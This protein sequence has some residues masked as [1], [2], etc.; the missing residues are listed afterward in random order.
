MAFAVQ[1]PRV[2]ERPRSRLLR[3]ALYWHLLSLDAPTVAVLWA[4]SFERAARVHIS[5]SALA[6]LGVGTWLIYVA[7]RL[8]DARPSRSSVASRTDLHERHFFH[9]R[10]RRTL[11]AVA[12]PVAAALLWLI[13]RM[14]AIDRRNDAILFAVA[15]LYF[16]SVHLA[17]P[18]TRRWFAR[19][20]MV[21]VVFA[22]ATAV[23][24]WSQ[25]HQSRTQMALL[26]LLFAA[27]CCLNTIA[28][29]VWEQSGGGRRFSVSR[30]AGVLAACAVAILLG[31]GAHGSADSA[32]VLCAGISAMVLLFLDHLH[33]RRS[34]DDA[35]PDEATRWLLLLRVAADAALLT[36][37]LFV[38]LW[39]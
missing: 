35:A 16:G 23:P 6:V 17:V 14:P 25:A 9:A 34:A 3:G 27:L 32:L 18:R 29:E 7:D 4:W 19:E 30:A 39:R 33:R 5:V 2:C 21:G 20:I 8:L 36:P 13:V 38:V 31:T 28:I 1:I 12:S 15:M 26:I 11:F 24:A 37:L 22:L 10:H